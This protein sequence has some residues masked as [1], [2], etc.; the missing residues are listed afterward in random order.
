MCIQVKEL[1]LY[2]REKRSHRTTLFV[3]KNFISTKNKVKILKISDL[4]SDKKESN[5]TKKAC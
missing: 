3:F 5:V 4:L 1:K 2:Q